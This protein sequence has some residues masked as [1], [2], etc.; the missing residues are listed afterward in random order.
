MTFHANARENA[1]SN[2]FGTP[3]GAG[4]HDNFA[5]SMSGGGG[6]VSHAEA[7]AQVEAELAMALSPAKP[8][9]PAV[10]S[11]PVAS[12]QLADAW[13]NKA[14][15]LYRALAVR[16]AAYFDFVVAH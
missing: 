14:Q 7:E 10:A 4:A 6:V 12:P 9:S 8:G 3:R 5:S 11:A 15:T 1:Y 2:V 13:R 16:F